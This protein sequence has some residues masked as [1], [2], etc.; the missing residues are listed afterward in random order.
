MVILYLMG[1]LYNQLTYNFVNNNVLFMNHCVITP[2]PD[3]LAY[4]D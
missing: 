2:I 3:H 4:Y 1:N